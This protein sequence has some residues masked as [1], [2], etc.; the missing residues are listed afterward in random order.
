M[1]TGLAADDALKFF[2]TDTELKKEES[3]K[4]EK[5]EEL[6]KIWKKHVDNNEPFNHSVEP[7]TKMSPFKQFIKREKHVSHLFL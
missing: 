3:S 1:Q 4:V 2:E 6:Q 5:L 7:Y